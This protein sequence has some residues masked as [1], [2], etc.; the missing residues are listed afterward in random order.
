M[1]K[2]ENGPA[3]VSDGLPDFASAELPVPPASTWRIVGPGIV[4][5]GV[6]LASGE[7]I[8]YPYIASQVGLAFVWAAQSGLSPSIS[9]T[10]KSSAIRSRRGR[11][12]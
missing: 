4:A 10:W 3:A 6:G 5:A 11:P 12:S 8:L 7:F 9:S 1:E 2:I